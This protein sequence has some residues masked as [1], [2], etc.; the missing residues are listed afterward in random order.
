MEDIAEISLLSTKYFVH[1]S[2]VLFVFIKGIV[3]ISRLSISETFVICMTRIP[4]CFNPFFAMR[5]TTSC[6][7]SEN[8]NSVN[9]SKVISL[10]LE[11]NRSRNC[12]AYTTCSNSAGKTK[13]IVPLLLKRVVD[14]TTKATHEFISL[15]GTS[16]S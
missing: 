5:T 15:L 10:Y 14:A 2:E 9:V 1:F 11:I 16:P 12:L 3:S 7:M 13:T 8:I 4:L 6:S